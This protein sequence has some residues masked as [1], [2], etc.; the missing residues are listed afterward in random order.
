MSFLSR[1]HFLNTSAATLFATQTQGQTASPNRIKAAQI[2]TKHPHAEGKFTTMVELADLFEVVGLC[3]EDE[4]QRERV[5][6]RRSYQSSRW[7]TADQIL[8]D[9]EIKLVAVETEI[10]Q[11]VPTAMRC[12]KAGKHIHLDKPAGQK[13]TPCKEMHREADQRGLTIQMGYMLRYNPA[14]EFLFQAVKEGWLGEITEVHGHMGKKASPGLRSELSKYPGG[15]L[16]ELA[17]HL[18]DALVTILGK[19]N[20]VHGV[21]VKTEEDAFKDNQIATFQYDRALATIGSNHNDPFGGPRRQFTVVGTEGTVAIQPLEPP[22]VSLSLTKDR[23]DFKRGTQQVP[24]LK[25]EGRYHWEF[26]DM[27]KV[28]KGEKSLAWN[29]EHDLIVQ[30]TLMRASGLPLDE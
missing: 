14:F 8:G 23:G 28:V 29:S 4:A 26:R 20:E 27:A 25:T 3:E 18:I 22:K 6:S 16:F 17:C 9:P 12:L 21:H 11:L 24:M 7:L 1:R 10:D 19:P 5:S 13:L 30:E 2:G 15:G